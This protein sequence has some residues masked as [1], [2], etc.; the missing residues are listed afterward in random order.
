MKTKRLLGLLKVYNLS[1]DKI[2]RE[3]E[4]ITWKVP[5]KY[6]TSSHSNT[7]TADQVW[8]QYPTAVLDLGLQLP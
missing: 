2:P 8:S 3:M 7:T 4:Y 5:L 1:S 6:P